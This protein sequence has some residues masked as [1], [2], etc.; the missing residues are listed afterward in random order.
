MPEKILST[1]A[2]HTPLGRLGKPEEIADAYCWLASD[3][4]SFVTGM[5]LS[6]RRRRSRGNIGRLSLE[7]AQL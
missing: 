7:G 3:G 6:R 5:V 2:S 1:M 4:A